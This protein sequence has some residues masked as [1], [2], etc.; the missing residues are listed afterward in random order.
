[1]VLGAGPSG[2]AAAFELTRHG[3]P[4]HVIERAS[5]VGGLART[6]ERDGFRFD[7]GGHR[8]F[9]KNDELN[10]L[11]RA[12]LAGE[13]VHVDRVSR[14]YY[15][16]RYVHYPLRL[17]DVVPNIGL[18]LGARALADYARARW[19]PVPLARCLL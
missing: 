3:R 13:I 11:F 17:G 5:V 15:G 1:V 8:W 18:G 7:I 14:I 12:L 9:T 10:D 4:A 16:G 19:Q 6:I 2:L